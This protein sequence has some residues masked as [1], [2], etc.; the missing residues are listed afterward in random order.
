MKV[1]LITYCFSPANVVGSKRWSDFYKLSKQDDQL[2][3]DVLSANWP[4][5]KIQDNNVKYLGDIQ[6]RSPSYSLQKKI[7]LKNSILHPS[8]FIR[9][10]DKSFFSSWIEK[11]KNWIDENQHKNYDY[12]VASYGPLSN[13]LVGNYAKKKF[14]AP[15][16]LD[17]RDLISIQGQKL[18]LPFIH[19]FD[20]KVDKFL[21]KKADLFLTVSS[22]GQ[23]KAKSFYRRKVGLIFNGFSFP[24][25][26]KNS[27]LTIKNKKNLNL[28]YTGTLGINRNPKYIIHILNEF[29]KQNDKT[30]ITV[31]FASQD[32]PLDFLSEKDHDKIKIK[33]LGFLSQKE[34]KREKEKSN[35]LLL[36]E[37]LTSNGNENLT[38]K[39][40]EYFS[41][42]KPILVSCNT[43][44][45][46]GKVIKETNTGSIV[47]SLQELS[48]FIDAD[49]LRNNENCLKY[50]RSNQ[51]GELKKL[52]INFPKR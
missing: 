26:L 6:N 37:D 23:K 43:N 38:A 31:R 9:S 24:I 15:F 46:I 1:L 49:R 41:S 47:S 7:N 32:N 14:N 3:F 50:S 30:K 11:C 52:L 19:F 10:I 33:W 4:G 35:I 27:D 5:D 45:D 25:D 29:A 51:Y 22:T 34:L 39:I 2:E 20:Q 48:E 17:L 8:L 12:I 13:I 40:Y 28:I 16:V 21:T 42:E 44:S 36:L 18:K